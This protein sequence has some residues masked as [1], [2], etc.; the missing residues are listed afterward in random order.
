M[1]KE[2][3]QIATERGHEC[4]YALDLPDYDKT[5]RTKVTDMI[6]ASD[7]QVGLFTNES[8]YFTR[9]E[10]AY[11]E[12]RGKIVV[13]M[14][15]KG[16]EGAQ[17]A[18]TLSLECE[19]FDRRNLRYHA[20]RVL[21]YLEA[22]YAKRAAVRSAPAAL[23]ERPVLPHALEAA[24]AAIP[25]A[26]SYVRPATMEEIIM[27]SPPVPAWYAKNRQY[28]RM[29]TDDIAPALYLGDVWG[30]CQSKIPLGS[31]TVWLTGIF[32]VKHDFI[33]SH[34]LTQ[35]EP[36]PQ[37]STYVLQAARIAAGLPRVIKADSS[38]KHTPSF[39]KDLEY[40]MKSGENTLP[41]Y[42]IDD[43]R[44]AW[45]KKFQETI[46][47]KSTMYSS[48]I[49]D[50]RCSVEYEIMSHNF[51]KHPYMREIPAE[52]AG[53]WTHFDNV[54]DMYDYGLLT[55][56]NFIIMLGDLIE[57]VDFSYK[58]EGNSIHVTI[59]PG[60]GELQKSM[61]EKILQGCNFSPFRK[62]WH[63]DIS[64]QKMNRPYREQIYPKNTFE[65]CCLCG[66]VAH[67]MQEM[68]LLNG[69]M[70]DRGL[71]R[72]Q[73]RCRRCRH[74]T[75]NPKKRFRIY[76]VRPVDNPSRCT[77]DPFLP[78][79][80]LQGPPAPRR[81]GDPDRFIGRGV[82]TKIGEYRDPRGL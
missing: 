20:E 79:G 29:L 53:F 49:D 71:I 6:K 37:I 41:R 50:L 81:S 77:L 78:P 17:S 80:Q 28:P 5:P 44:L 75:S 31:G 21:K 48:D 55:E 27:G 13:R 43:G 60:V 23:G 3:I 38:H 64:S 35:G 51:F 9:E 74:R 34:S 26:V 69:M 24:R 46:L 19:I 54:K 82:Q 42:E 8:S 7:A 45:F 73:P 59:Q 39:R 57:H 1:A 22:K 18:F 25:K 15:E 76:L 52:R 10:S 63:R 62:Y 32:D 70:Y 72:S 11:A 47:K 16:T 2:F 58:N 67:S 30:L 36:S 68:L 4:L 65:K 66:T 56:K 33:L 61:I 40:A 12:G 14:V